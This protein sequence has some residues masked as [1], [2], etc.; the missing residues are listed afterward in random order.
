MSVSLSRFPGWLR[1]AALLCLLTLGAVLAG[2]AAGHWYRDAGT[3]P[4]V[5]SFDPA[6]MTIAT[7]PEPVLIATSSCPACASARAW[8]DARG[9][10]YRELTADQSADARA[11]AETLDVSIVPTFLIGDERINGFHEQELE[12]RLAATIRTTTP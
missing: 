6:T 3:R 7:A 4:A 10:R 1:D 5:E 12:S 11:I 2:T 8:L 9:I